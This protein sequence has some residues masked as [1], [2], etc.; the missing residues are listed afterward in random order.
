MKYPPGSSSSCNPTPLVRVVHSADPTMTGTVPKYTR[1]ALSP[2]Y[3]TPPR[4]EP[5]QPLSRALSR[6]IATGSSVCT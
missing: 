2:L 4:Q 3:A 1:V 6:R 5:G